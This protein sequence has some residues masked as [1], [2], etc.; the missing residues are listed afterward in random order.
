MYV[1]PGPQPIGGSRMA[2]FGHDVGP[3]S[4]GPPPA[5]LATDHGAGAGSDSAEIA[6]A[7]HGHNGNARGRDHALPT[8][9]RYVYR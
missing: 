1:Y 8:V 3:T 4:G 5:T 2:T 9:G 7:A 6:F